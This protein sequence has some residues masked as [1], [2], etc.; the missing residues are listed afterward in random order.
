M[1]DQELVHTPEEI[2]EILPVLRKAVDAYHQV[3]LALADQALAE[4]ELE[5]MTGCLKDISPLLE[6]LAGSI[7]SSDEITSDNV[8]IFLDQTH[9]LVMD[10]DDEEEDESEELDTCVLCDQDFVPDGDSWADL[11]PNCADRVS[12][13]MDEQHVDRQAAIA[14][15]RK[16]D[17]HDL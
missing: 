3:E 8:A 11:D 2:A 5:E 14:A 16:A 15:L 4:E 17:G 1:S 9:A 10:E 13:Y 6:A 12:G 7:S